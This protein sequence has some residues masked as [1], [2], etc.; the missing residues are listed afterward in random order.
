M[1]QVGDVHF[2]GP[3]RLDARA[4][5]L[6]R[7]GQPIALTGKAFDTLLVL[8]HHAGRVVSKEEILACV[9][10]D[11]VVSEGNLKQNVWMLRKALGEAKGGDEYIE[12]IP[13]LGYRLTARVLAFPGPPPLPVEERGHVR[14]RSRRSALGIALGAALALS[15]FLVVRAGRVLPP[16]RSLAILPF[17]SL[18]AGADDAYLGA[19][20]ADTLT[21]RLSAVPGLV[22]RPSSSVRTF[23]REEMPSAMVGRALGVDFVLEGSIQT[24]GAALRINSQL[25]RMSDNAPLWAE[26]LDGTTSE[27]FRLED[28][29]SSHVTEAL[30]IKVSRPDEQR[31]ARQFT[32]SQNAYRAYLRGRSYWNRRPIEPPA[33]ARMEFEQAVRE[34][35][36]YALAYAGIADCYLFEGLRD[37]ANLAKANGAIAKALALDEG[38]AEAHASLG[39]EKLF[40]EWDFEIAEKELRRAIHLNPGYVT[41]HQWYA[42][43][44]AATGRPDDAVRE[45][46]AARRIDPTSQTV[47]R[48]VGWI[49]YYARRY[50]A[51]IEE[52]RNAARLDPADEMAHAFLQAAYLERS[53]YKQ[54]RDEAEVMKAGHGLPAASVYARMGRSEQAHRILDDVVSHF[55]AVNDGSDGIAS[56]Y[57]CLGETDSAMTWLERAYAD[58]RFYLI[59]LKADPKYDSLHGDPRFES[60]WKRVSGGRAG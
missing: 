33:K 51:A 49:L 34:D 7:G 42:F 5:S 60:L 56:V 14:R 44:L 22:V 47:T 3:F 28:A 43:L 11:A 16:T 41:A 23:M 37:P 2:F 52:L 21:T 6:T 36:N 55:P 35:P 13:K 45:I 31:L 8:V 24:S 57:A 58:H 12:T 20:V 27:I 29:L 48:D 15:G 46:E 10:P 9:W 17:R 38:L 53:L 50:D 19:G 32:R 59:F 40:Y 30:K 26:S 1:S 54:A 4:R 39:F 25:V 18:G